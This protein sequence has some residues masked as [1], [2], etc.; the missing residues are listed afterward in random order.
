[1][2]LRVSMSRP[3]HLRLL[4]AH[5]QRRADHLR[6]CRVNSVLS[7]SCWSVALATPK[8]ITLGTGW[9]SCSVTSTFDG[10]MSRWMI[11]F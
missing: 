6:E 8:S 11:P 9:P 10:L 4:G 1:M 5:V 3:A 2:S 7:V